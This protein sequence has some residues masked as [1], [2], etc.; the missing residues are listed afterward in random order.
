M[1]NNDLRAQL[2]QLHAELAKASRIE[3]Q[4]RRLLSDIL[5]DINRLLEPSSPDAAAKP[6]SSNSSIAERLELL[7]VEF[8]ADHPALAASTRRFVD[9]LGKVGL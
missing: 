1:G 9:L 3:P 6:A 8:E 4:D 7:A 5:S 2:A